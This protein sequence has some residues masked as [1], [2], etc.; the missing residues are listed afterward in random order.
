ML[1]VAGDRFDERTDFAIY[2]G[3][4]LDFKWVPELRLHSLY[5]TDQLDNVDQVEVRD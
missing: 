2:L 1:R 4:R 3:N 5:C